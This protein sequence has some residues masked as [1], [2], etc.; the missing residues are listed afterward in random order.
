MSMTAARLNLGRS[1]LPT[2]RWEGNLVAN[3]VENLDGKWLDVLEQGNF[4]DL[5]KTWIL[6]KR[7]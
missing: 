5:R 6:I 4:H 2:L 3:N 1:Q 7:R